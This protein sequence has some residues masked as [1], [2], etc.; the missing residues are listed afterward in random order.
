MNPFF[1]G[2][3]FLLAGC[4]VGPDYT[5]PSVKTPGTYKEATND[6]KVATPQDAV[7]QKSWWTVF[8]DPLL[9]DLEE[10]AG[11]VNYSL[12]EAEASYRQALAVVEGAKANFFPSAQLAGTDTKE[13]INDLD[14]PEANLSLLI[15]NPQ[16]ALQATWEPDLWGNVRRQVEADEAAA[17]GS[18]ASMASVRLSVQ[19][20]LAQDYFQICTLDMLQV[21]LDEKVAAY[22]RLLARI[23][24]QYQAGTSSQLMVLQTEYELQTAQ[25]Q[26]ID[27]KISR[28]QYEHAIA[29]LIG[30]APAKFS[31][32]PRTL[33]TKAPEIPLEVPSILLERRPDIAQAERMM[34]QANAEI[35]V[36]ESAYFPALSLSGSRGYSASAYAHF[37]S[38]PNIVWSVGANLTQIL[39]DGGAI[40]ARVDQ[41]GEGYKSA[42]AAY[43]QT[44]L[45]A[46]QDVE[47]NLA[48]VR[49]LNQEVA[50]LHES[51][52]NAERQYRFTSHGFVAGT[53]S[54]A[55]VLPLLIN[56]YQVKQ[57]SVTA[58]GRLMTAVVGLI[59]AL[60]GGYHFQ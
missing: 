17:E 9:N 27:N 56:L 6:W 5:R 37:F 57:N 28:A 24:N 33:P 44:V 8:N 18:F 41:A 15:L 10:K 43:R 47:D 3:I 14:S 42:V 58:E 22:E 1:L 12:A 51:I 36:A 32:P 39:F 26:A 50:I 54:V 55:D 35:G 60:G 20:T 4:S 52:R 19:A 30:E 25:T 7:Y 2:I 40:M 29:V 31:I 11:K 21:L 49:I 48:S 45:A 23:K 38:T 34:A 53:Q 13:R 16:L 59:K 46:F